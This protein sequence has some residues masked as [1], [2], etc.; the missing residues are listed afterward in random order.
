MI[1]LLLL[2]K[3][4]RTV[5]LIALYFGLL[6]PIFGGAPPVFA[7]AAKHLPHA[8]GDHLPNARLSDGYLSRTAVLSA[9]QSNHSECLQRGV[10]VQF[11]DASLLIALWQPASLASPPAPTVASINRSLSEQAFSLAKTVYGRFPGVFDEVQCAFF[12]TQAPDTARTYFIKSSWFHA[13]AAG[14][15]GALLADMP[16]VSDEGPSLAEVYGK[17]SYRQILDR[18]PATEAQSGPAGLWSAERKELSDQLTTLRANGYDVSQATGQLCAIEDLVR[19]RH[20]DLLPQAFARTRQ[21]L[22]QTV[23][24][25]Q[26]IS[27]ASSRTQNWQR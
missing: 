14:A 2:M 5:P 3:A 13:H 18:S 12:D 6:Q 10:D 15:K 8:A 17:L 23:S 11:V 16:V 21:C 24:N 20:Y 19:T 25:A 4:S 27:V 9:L 1:N 7:R 22:A 26:K